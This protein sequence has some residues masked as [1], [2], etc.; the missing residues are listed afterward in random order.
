MWGWEQKG[1][2][3]GRMKGDGP[4]KDDFFWEAF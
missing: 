2:G 1:S 4:G 3:W